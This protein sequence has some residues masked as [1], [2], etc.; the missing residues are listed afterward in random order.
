MNSAVKSSPANFKYFVRGMTKLFDLFGDLL[1]IACGR[2][3][4]WFWNAT[5]VNKQ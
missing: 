3:T 1:T 5:S 2:N 4:W